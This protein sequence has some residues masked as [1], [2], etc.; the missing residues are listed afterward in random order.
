MNRLIL[1][2]AVAALAFA[3]PAQAATLVFDQS[4]YQEDDR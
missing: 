1:P 3:A 4:C 2:L